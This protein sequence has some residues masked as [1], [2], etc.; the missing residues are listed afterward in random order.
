MEKKGKNHVFTHHTDTNPKSQSYNIPTT[1]ATSTAP[2]NP[3]TVAVMPDAPLFP[4]PLPLPVGIG[5][6]LIPESLAHFD[7]NVGGFAV[8]VISAHCISLSY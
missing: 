5:S 3:P 1:A 6:A 8:N 7:V 2:T 4:L